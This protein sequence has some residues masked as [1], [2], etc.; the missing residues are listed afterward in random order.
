LVCKN[1][2]GRR[3]KKILRYREVSTG[4]SSHGTTSVSGNS[5]WIGLCWLVI[6]LDVAMFIFLIRLLTFKSIHV[7]SQS[8]PFKG[9][10]AMVKMEFAEIFP[11]QSGLVNP[12][13]HQ[14]LDISNF[15]ISFLL[16]FL[17]INSAVEEIIYS[18]SE[19]RK[20]RM[21]TQDVIDSISLGRLF[22]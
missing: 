4:N 7:L 22:F 13:F 21:L 15:V 18:L 8:Y 14:H 12:K 3:K 1:C 10:F 20:N 11:S 19:E 16:N 6:I 5:C 2:D 9:Y 17:A